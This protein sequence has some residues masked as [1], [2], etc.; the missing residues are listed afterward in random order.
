DV[1]E[2]FRRALHNKATIAKTY[3][4][5]GPQVVT[6][7]E[8]VR[9]T[10]KIA[11]M[12]CRIV[13]LPDFVAW[14]QGMVMGLLPGKPFSLDNYRSLTVDS[15]CTDNGCAKLGIQ[16]QP[17]L[18]IVPTYLQPDQLGLRVPLA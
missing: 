18:A 6:L 2:A 3:E 14:L 5:C 10:A 9:L 16:P 11:E 12:P 15:V 1:V 13:R 8:L 4:L 7:E 17:L